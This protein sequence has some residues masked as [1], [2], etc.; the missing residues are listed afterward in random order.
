MTKF[1]HLINRHIHTIK[2]YVPGKPIADLINK[3]P[4]KKIIKLASNENPLGP[5]PKALEVMQSSLKDIARYPVSD[6]FS[7]RHKLAEKHA[8][9]DECITLG[10]GSNEVLS[11]IAKTFLNPETEV[12]ISQYAFLIYKIASQLTGANIVETPAYNWG[13][14]LKAMQEAI[15]DKTRVILIANPNNPTGTI[16]YAKQLIGFLENV[17]SEIMVVLDEAYHEYIQNIEYKSGTHWLEKYPNLIVVRSFSKIYGLAGLRIGY[18]IA[19]PEVANTLHRIRAPF[20]VNHLAQVAA[21]A[22]LED[23]EHMQKSIEL[24]DQGREFLQQSFDKLG[25]KYL[26][27]NGNFITIDLQKPAQPVY[28]Q[29]LQE[30]LIVRPLNNYQMPNHLRITIGLPEEN[31]LFIETLTKILAPGY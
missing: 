6:G 3:L 24:N 14:D 20:N 18:C 27:A 22:S 23:E 31:K 12:I 2:P 4:N 17:P 11:L 15:S 7:L 30:G 5:S 10:N 1:E 16:L 29:L 19:Q 25:I 21:E 13:H 26:P 28:E 9:P 8:I